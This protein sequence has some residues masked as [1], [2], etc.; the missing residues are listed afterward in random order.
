MRDRFR[1]TFG[2]VRFRVTIA[3]ALVFGIA[4]GI[5]SMVLVRTVERRLEDRAENDGR[6]AIE[7]AAA[8]IRAGEDLSDVIVAT[9]TPVFTWVIGPTGRVL[10]GSAFVPPGFDVAT[11]QSSSGEE[12]ASPAGDIVLFTQRVRGP[13]GT[14]TV[15]VASPLDSAQRSAETL[16]RGLWLLTALLTLGVGV[17]A[18][19]IAGRALRPVEAIRSEVL[20][21][22]STTM[23]RRVPVPAGRDEVQRLAATMNEML[24]RL[25]EASN[26][27]REFVSDASH[28]LR[29]PVASMRAELEVALRAP[30]RVEWQ[31]LATRLLAENERLGRLVADL[32]ELARLEE[33]QRDTTSAPVDMDE[34]VLEDIARRSAPPRFE[35]AAV[36][37]GRALGSARQLTQVVHNLLDNAGRHARGTVAVSVG[38]DDGQVLLTV[39]DDGPGIAEEDR[40]RVFDRFARL[41][42]GRARDAGG[43]G[44][45]LALVKRIVETH[46]GTVRITDGTGPGGA[47]FEVRLPSSN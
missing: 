12:M 17:L 3:A 35:T 14:V 19:F 10:Y 31:P 38:T 1:R 8:Q 20:A 46:G 29:S 4:F 41:D 30:D 37:G 24:D 34:L 44:L 16:G 15:A 45:G 33:G 40:S 9:R 39:E 11:S 25:E 7:A 21:I 43:S 26:R 23:H 42:A 13:D 36:T 2:S 28:E 47:R 27:Q 5:A 18:W 6:L 22:T 32:L